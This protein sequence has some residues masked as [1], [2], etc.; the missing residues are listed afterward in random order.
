MI[1]WCGAVNGQGID[2][3]AAGVEHVTGPTKKYQLPLHV[4]THTHARAPPPP[5]T[6]DE[7]AGK[8]GKGFR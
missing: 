6:V 4:D 7:K 5:L 3:R 2:P 1:S 8:K